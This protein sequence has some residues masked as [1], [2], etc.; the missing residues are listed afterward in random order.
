TSAWTLG[1]PTAGTTNVGIP[2]G[3]MSALRINELLATNSVGTDGLELFNPATNPPVA[4]GG[5]VF[6]QTN[7]MT[8]QA[9]LRPNSFI[10]SD[11]F[12]QF[13]CVG[14]TNRGDHLEFKLSS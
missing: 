2:L 7:P 13:L 6:S 12:I 3:L 10:D 8:N 9:A 14:D 4:I 1:L 11:G 5:M